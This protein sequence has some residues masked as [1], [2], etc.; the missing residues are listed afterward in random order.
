[1]KIMNSDAVIDCILSNICGKHY[2]CSASQL[3][4]WRL[5]V[6]I[7]TR[8]HKDR[9]VVINNLAICWY[10]YGMLKVKPKW[11]YT[12]ESSFSSVH[13]LFEQIRLFHYGH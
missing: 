2:D 12:I 4:K 3:A 13:F 5:I 6:I 1:M 10:T 11:F 7:G 9:I 8:L